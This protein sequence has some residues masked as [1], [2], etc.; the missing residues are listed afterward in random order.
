MFISAIDL[1]AFLWLP[2]DVVQSAFRNLSAI[3]MAE[4]Q[5]LLDVYFDKPGT[6]FELWTPLDWHEK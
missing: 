4:L 1:C 3:S 5:V 2:A 6:E